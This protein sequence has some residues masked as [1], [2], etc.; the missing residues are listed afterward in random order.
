MTKEKRGKERE[1]T[2]SPKNTKHE[3]EKKN[4]RNSQ[5][6]QKSREIKTL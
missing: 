5:N 6:G 2:G 1:K 3:G 4:R